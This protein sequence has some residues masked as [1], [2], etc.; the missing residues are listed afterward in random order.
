MIRYPMMGAGWILKEVTEQNKVISHCIE[1]AQC[2]QGG[3]SR[4]KSELE[5]YSIGKKSWEDCR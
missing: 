1:C 4:T 5:K 2:I 3:S